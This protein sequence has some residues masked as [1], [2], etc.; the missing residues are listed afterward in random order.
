M[1][2]YDFL[3]TKTEEVEEHI[4]KMSE[5]DD[6]VKDNPHLQRQFTAPAL[7]SS[8]GGNIVS[9]TSGDWR[10]HIKRIKKQSGR[11]NTIKTY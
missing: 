3:N 2:S 4:M 5:Y 10:D 7:I 8:A 9:Q 1:P 6:F 11:G